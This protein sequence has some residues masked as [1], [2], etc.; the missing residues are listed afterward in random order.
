MIF[1]A[2]KGQSRIYWI[3]VYNLRLSYYIIHIERINS[4]YD[5]QKPFSGTIPASDIKL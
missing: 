2:F 3:S 4:G 1:P 5:M